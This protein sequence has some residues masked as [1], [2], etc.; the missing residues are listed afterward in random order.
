MASNMLALLS[1]LI[2]ELG[3]FDDDALAR[4]DAGEDG[5]VGA[6]DRHGAY[7]QRLEAFGRN[8]RPHLSA[9]RLRR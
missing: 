6:I 2:D 8:L 5:D 1:H 9:A 7:G 4:L 3:A